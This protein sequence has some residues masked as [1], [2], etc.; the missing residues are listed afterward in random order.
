MAGRPIRGGSGICGKAM[1]R[2][3]WK[4]SLLPAHSSGLLTLGFYVPVYGLVWAPWSILTEEE[5]WPELGFGRFVRY[6]ICGG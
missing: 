3:G 4:G 1:V 6:P 5:T 2:C